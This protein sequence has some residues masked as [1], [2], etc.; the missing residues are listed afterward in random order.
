[1]IALIIAAVGILSIGNVSIFTPKIKA[2]TYLAGVSGLKSGDVVML[3]GVEVGNVSDVR[4]ARDTPPTEANRQAQQAINES[5]QRLEIMQARLLGRRDQ[6]NAMRQ[7]YEKLLQQD[8]QKARVMQKDI[9]RFQSITES[10]MREL[11]NA[12]TKLENAKGSLQNIEVTLVLEKKYESMIRRDSN[13]SLGSVGLMGDKYIDIS[14]GRSS[15]PPERDK[16]GTII[17]AGSKVTDIRQIMTGVDDIIANFGVLSNRLESVMAKFDEGQGSIGK[18]I[19]DPAFYD[20][21]NST[22]LSAQ[23][24]VGSADTL[25]T[26]VQQG[27]GTLGKFMTDSQVYDSLAAT[28]D[29]F[30]VVVDRINSKE[31]SLGKFINDTAI[32]D[33]ANSTAGRVDDMIA[34]VDR[35]EGNLGKLYRDEALYQN[36]RDSLQRV[37]ALLE[38]INAG[39]GTL[40]K[41]AKDQEMYNNL[42]QASSEMVKLIYDFRKNPKKYLTVKFQIF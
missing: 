36:V 28:A 9:D 10:E 38:D 32:Y 26:G 6:L 11:D 7:Q 2:K 24:T 27:R 29:K 37:N 19:N 15:L 5:T 12:K 18:F 41:L 20:N 17:I 3:Q 16:D 1:M 34:R 39:K 4:I 21:L 40:G 13:V 25:L 14:L 33:R 35:G 30:E 22:V 23:K 31:G 42:N 8:P